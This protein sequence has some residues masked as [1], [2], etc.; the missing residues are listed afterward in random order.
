MGAFLGRQ[1]A[2]RRVSETWPDPDL[3]APDL[4]FEI[5]ARLVDYIAALGTG[6]AHTGRVRARRVSAGAQPEIEAAGRAT[7]GATSG[8]GMARSA[9][10]A[11][12]N[13]S[14]SAWWRVSTCMPTGSPSIEPGGD[15]HRGVAVEVRDHGEA[16]HAARGRGNA[17]ANPSSSADGNFGATPTAIARTAASRAAEAEP[18]H[19]VR[20]REVDDA[21]RV[22]LLIGASAANT[23]PG[24]GRGDDEVDLLERVGHRPVRLD[25]Q[26][27]GDRGGVQVVERLRQLQADRD[28]GR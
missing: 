18:G 5:A 2:W 22:G 13:S 12:S 3:G 15:R 23:V 6:A 8:H 25:S 17:C 9:A 16:A 21:R 4:G 14:A 1:D 24:V 19:R 10:S 7:V 27:L 20:L 28:L 26:L 11:T